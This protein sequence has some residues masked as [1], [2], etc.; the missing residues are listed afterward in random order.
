M[1]VYAHDKFAKSILSIADQLLAL[2]EDAQPPRWGDALRVLRASADEAWSIAN[3]FDARA[4]SV[5]GRPPTNEL[6]R[7]FSGHEL[8]WLSDEYATFAEELLWLI[9]RS[10]QCVREGASAAPTTLPRPRYRKAFGLA[11]IWVVEAARME[12]ERANTSTEFG[13]LTV[14]RASLLGLIERHQAIADDC[15]RQAAQIRPGRPRKSESA[16]DR[17][18]AKTPEPAAGRKIAISILVELDK[19]PKLKV[20]AALHLIAQRKVGATDARR[21]TP[22]FVEAFKAAV[23]REVRSMQK[24]LSRWRVKIPTH[25]KQR[26]GPSRRPH[27]RPPAG[28]LNA[29]ISAWR[30]SKLPGDEDG[31]T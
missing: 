31:T 29:A 23:E 25:V 11:D 16:M 21:D 8:R 18:T 5:K 6:L 24:E 26:P 13:E 17:P 7:G 19:D 14:L 1:R 22:F 30:L 20:P 4:R 3:R 10:I 27:S 9:R 12:A 28:D 15:A 2:C